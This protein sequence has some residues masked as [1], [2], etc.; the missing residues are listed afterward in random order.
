MSHSATRGCDPAVNPSWDPLLTSSTCCRPFHTPADPATRGQQPSGCHRKGCATPRVCGNWG[1]R[2]TVSVAFV[3][4]PDALIRTSHSGVKLVGP[5]VPMR[6]VAKNRPTVTGKPAPRAQQSHP[7]AAVDGD[8]VPRDGT[9]V[10]A[11]SEGVAGGSD[12]LRV[13]QSNFPPNSP[14]SPGGCVLIGAAAVEGGVRW[15]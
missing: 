7:G 8:V 10:A 2:C 12:W 3:I 1:H 14:H 11:G 15:L 4:S 6:P 5:G 13:I 9:V